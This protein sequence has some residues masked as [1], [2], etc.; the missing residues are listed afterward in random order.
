MSW[1]QLLI[2]L[3]LHSSMKGCLQ[4]KKKNTQKEL[5]LKRGK[6]TVIFRKIRQS[7]KTLSCYSANAAR[8]SPSVLYKFL[9][10]FPCGQHWARVFKS[11]VYNPTDCL[12][13]SP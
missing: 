13:C 10:V 1:S 2:V 8:V 4:K 6:N 7:T 9:K 12:H 5:C 11:V 3:R